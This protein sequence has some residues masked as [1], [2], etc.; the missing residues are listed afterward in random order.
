MHRIPLIT[1]ALLLTICALSTHALAQGAT[2]EAAGITFET[3]SAQDLDVIQQNSGY[4]LGVQVQAV[5][6]GSAGAA[7]GLKATDVVFAIGKTGVDSAE[8]AA[9]ALK[10]AS[11][12][13]DLPGMTLVNGTFEVKVFKLTLGAPANSP[14]NAK[15][16][17]P[18]A[19]DDEP[20]VNKQTTGLLEAY[21]D[22]MDF[23]RTQ[24]WGRPVRTSEPER[25][26]VALQLQQ[27]Q[28]DQH[29]A[30]V[31]LQIPQAWPAVQQQ[32]KKWSDAQKNKQRAEWR[33]QLLVPGG[34][35]PAPA[36]AQTYT[37]P[38]NL[39]SLQYPGTW[40]GGMTEA[41][42]TPL[43]FMGP[44]G[45]QAQWERVVDT[46]QSPDGALFALAEITNDM[47]GMSYLQAAHYL[48]RLLIPSGLDKLRIVQELPIA[49]MGAVIT[50]AGTFAGQ[51][52]EKFFWIGVAKFGD[53]Q[54]FAGR[55]GGSVKNAETLIPAFTYML[56]TLQ[57]N[58]P[59]AAADGG[60]GT[61]GAWDA[62]WSRVDVAI[63]KNIW[64]PSGN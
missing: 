19:K 57:L 38:Q 3:L 10:A 52:D 24:A 53:S 6:P 26:R 30:S 5:K 22:M 1:A 40:S 14:T 21:F 12:A 2:A 62:A 17:A 47:K 13:L 42:G 51:S 50:L 11:G 29:S 45:S 36:D 31:L 25:R 43:L 28:L 44:N 49:N 27:T 48:A 32:W 20:L 23:I 60:G 34:L 46:P 33:D 56:E 59:Q 64:A 39:V 4:R 55:M 15:P 58:P 41:N 61:S 8:K 9:A 18:P 16:A 54:I 37:A 35:Y 7:A 63:T